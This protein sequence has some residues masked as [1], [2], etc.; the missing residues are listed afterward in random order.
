VPVSRE[1]LESLCPLF[2]P[3]AEVIADFKAKQRVEM[4]AAQE[5]I[6]SMLQRRPCTALEISETFNMHLN[7][8]SKYLGKLLREKQIRA[9]VA[10]TQLY[11]VADREEARS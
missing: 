11:Y 3:Q 6:Y 2:A 10:N 7:E 1:R 9:Q 4:H 8:V 5:E